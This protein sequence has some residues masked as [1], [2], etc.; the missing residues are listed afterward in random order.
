MSFLPIRHYRPANGADY[1]NSPFAHRLQQIAVLIKAESTPM[2]ALQKN[3][4]H[5]VNSRSTHS[6]VANHCPYYLLIFKIS[7][8]GKSS[9]PNADLVACLTLDES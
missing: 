6:A 7:M 9:S 8:M 2:S 4:V 5:C 1:A 3:G